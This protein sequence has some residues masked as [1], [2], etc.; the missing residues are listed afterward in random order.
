MARCVRCGERI[1]R[2][3]DARCRVCHEVARIELAAR[4]QPRGLHEQPDIG[5]AATVRPY[6]ERPRM[7][8]K[9][10][11]LSPRQAAKLGTTRS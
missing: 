3:A 2:A 4:T 7:R 11:H 9:A 8:T 5:D 10:T 6:V 1:N